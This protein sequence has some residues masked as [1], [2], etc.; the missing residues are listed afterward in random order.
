[1]HVHV[2]DEDPISESEY[3]PDVTRFV[4]LWWLVACA[5]QVAT[6]GEHQ[7]AIDREDGD[8]LAA[9]LSALPGAVRA[10]VTL[11]RAVRDPFT[12]DSSPA[13]AAAIVVVDDRADRDAVARAAAR[14]MHAAAPEIASPDIAIELGAVRPELASVGPFTVEAR[15]RAPLVATLA[16]ALAVIAALAVLVAWRERQRL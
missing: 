14:L 16:T 6:P 10:E 5:P 3:A 12:R 4:L 11:H 7:R 8:R 13:S 9:Q 15:S 2:H 1:M